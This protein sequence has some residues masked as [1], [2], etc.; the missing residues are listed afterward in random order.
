M[1]ESGAGFT[2]VPLGRAGTGEALIL[3]QDRDF[4]QFGQQVL[5]MKAQEAQERKAADRDIGKLLSEDISTKWTEDTLNYFKPKIDSFKKEVIDTYKENKGRLSPIQLY[6]LNNKWSTIK[7]EATLN[8]ELFTEEQKNREELKKDLASENPVFDKEASAAMRAIYNNPY[9]IPE[10]AKQIN[11][12]Y[13]GNVNAWRAANRD[14]F[15]NI[16]AF[17]P[18]DYI[19]DKFKDKLSEEYV[20]DEKGRPVAQRDAAGHQYYTKIKG[21]NEKNL[22]T[23]IN[24]I[25]GGNTYKD[26]RFKE[27]YTKQAEMLPINYQKGAVPTLQPEGLSP[28]QFNYLAT[29][30]KKSPELASMTAEQQKGFMAKKLAAFDA[31]ATFPA[32]K[33]FEFYHE[34]KPDKGD[35]LRKDL[36]TFTPTTIP[37]RT[38]LSGTAATIKQALFSKQVP[39]VALNY[40]KTATDN[41]PLYLN[42]GRQVNPLGF[43]KTKNGW[44]LVGREVKKI[45]DKF[46]GFTTKEEQVIVPFSNTEDVA[47]MAA[48]IGYDDVNEFQKKLE[49]EIT[50]TGGAK[51]PTA[52]STQSTNFKGVPKGGF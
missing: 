26:T 20:T 1:P 29:T 12:Q 36:F 40:D 35:K 45:P 9:K 32:T 2:Q 47:R 46:G 21:V 27:Y 31:R 51:T 37:E 38:T 16:R 49:Q 8:N 4:T 13:G 17:N 24:T 23:E 14:Q 50:R 42:D 48:Y 6:Q 39:Y 7:Q 19:K 33:A 25:W 18:Q 28:D 41:S 30:I 5:R 44:E 15:Q 43:Q 3:P 34:Q 10:L 22:Q 52:T 11:E